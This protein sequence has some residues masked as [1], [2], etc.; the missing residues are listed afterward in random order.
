M[1]TATANDSHAPDISDSP[2]E[3]P[4]VGATITSFTEERTQPPR[5]PPGKW[6][7]KP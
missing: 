4:E 6:Q 5:S 2:Q 7:N 3:S 1:E